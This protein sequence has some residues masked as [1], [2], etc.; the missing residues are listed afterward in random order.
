MYRLERQTKEKRGYKINF[1]KNKIFI[2][3]YFTSSEGDCS[4]STLGVYEKINRHYVSFHV[5]SF[6]VSGIGC[7]MNYEK[8]DAD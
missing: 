6:S 3:S 8:I 7:Q 1:I 4:P 2:A 5:D